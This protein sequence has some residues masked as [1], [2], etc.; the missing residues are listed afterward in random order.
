MVAIDPLFATYKLNDAGRAKAQSIAEAFTELLLDLEQL[1]AL[2]GRHGSL[3]KTKLEEACQAAKKAV[4]V[5]P[6]YQE[7]A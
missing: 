1:G 2:E 4:A 6:K 7:A 3:V 5:Q